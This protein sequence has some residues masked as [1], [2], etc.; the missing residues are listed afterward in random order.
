MMTLEEISYSIMEEIDNFQ[1]KHNG[2]LPDCIFMSRPLIRYM[3]GSKELAYS[4]DIEDDGTGK[5]GAYNGINI[6]EYDYPEPQYYLASGPG[7]FR[8]YYKAAEVIL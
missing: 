6:I 4:Y 7:M 2:M 3:F 1:Y 5:I 8:A